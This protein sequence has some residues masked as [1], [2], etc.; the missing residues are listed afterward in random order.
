MRYALLA[1]VLVLAACADA[2]QVRMVHPGGTAVLCG[3]YWGNGPNGSIAATMQLD[4]C[5][6]DYQRQGFERSVN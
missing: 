4:R 5:I 3:P 1:M 2:P 6:I